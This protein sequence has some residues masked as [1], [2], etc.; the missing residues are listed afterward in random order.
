M[1]LILKKMCKA[2]EIILTLNN[3]SKKKIIITRNTC[4]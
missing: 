3:E 4:N 1:S 2:F